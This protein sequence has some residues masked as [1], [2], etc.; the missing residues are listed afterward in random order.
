MHFI[1]FVSLAFGFFSD[2]EGCSIDAISFIDKACSGKTS[3]EYYVVGP[4]LAA[5]QPCP[6]GVASYLEV[7]YECIKGRNVEAYE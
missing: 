3:C 2:H 6:R 1:L 5:S 7:R 4:D